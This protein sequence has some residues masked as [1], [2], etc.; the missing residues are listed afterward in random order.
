MVLKQP[1][2]STA[3]PKRRL[4]ILLLTAVLLTILAAALGAVSARFPRLEM[5]GYRISREEYLRAMY[6][7]RNEVL[8]DHAAA[9]IS[10]KNWDAET[11]LG[12]PRRLTMDRALE[13]LSEYYAVGT[14][15]VERGY[16]SD[17]GYDAM[18]R[19]MEELN[20]RRQE[21][22]AAGAIITGIPA[23]TVDDYI[24]YR[25][26]GLRLQF[27]SDPENPDYPVTDQELRQRYEADRDNLY[28]QP[29]SVDLAF[30][31]IE[32]GTSELEQ[33][34]TSL[35][36]KALETGSLAAALADFPLL[37]D[38]YLEIS[39]DPASFSLYSRSHG[40]VLACAEGLQPG[41]LSQ[42][43]CQDGWLCLV[44]CLR[45]TVQQYVPLEDAA[46]IV[47]QSIRE[48]RYDALIE[49]RM[50]AMELRGDLQALYRFTAEQLP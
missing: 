48:S 41:E 14:L 11:P 21:E 5:A 49:E 7:A 35:R 8:S 16:L 2:K 15:A 22:L 42:V 26:S 34:L 36:R 45:R 17:A 33:S 38:H 3:P 28:R 30:V 24:A 4:L 23:F 39:V 18:V 6:Q 40:D 47:A 44:Q 43:I 9:G 25:A 10:L 32:I 27:C 31:E 20:R 50:E 46:S 37:R 19:D 29:D 13:I 1:C 12:D